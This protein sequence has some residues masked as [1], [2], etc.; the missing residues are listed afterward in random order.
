MLYY[1]RGEVIFIFYGLGESHTYNILGKFGYNITLNQRVESMSNYYRSLS[2]IPIIKTRQ[3]DTMYGAGYRCFK[4][5][6][7]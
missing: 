5:R 2:N 3:V 4:G 1:A 6:P 7:R